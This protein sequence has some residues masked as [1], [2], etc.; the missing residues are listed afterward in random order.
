MSPH[1]VGSH[2]CHREPVSKVV[3]NIEHGKVRTGMSKWITD[4]APLLGRG[5]ALFVAP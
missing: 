2:R 5:N 1:G 4:L 3:G